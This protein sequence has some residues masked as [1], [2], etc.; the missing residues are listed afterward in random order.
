MVGDCYAHLRGQSRELGELPRERV[1]QADRVGRLVEQG[2][3]ALRGGSELV[4]AVVPREL[5]LDALPGGDVEEA[6]PV[7]AS[8]AGRRGLTEH[9]PPARVEAAVQAPPGVLGV[10]RRHPRHTARKLT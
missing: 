7:A 8:R 1:Q 6:V 5:R 4:V 10:P 2:E 9:D 3:E